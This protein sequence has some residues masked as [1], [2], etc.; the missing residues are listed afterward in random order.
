M[1]CSISWQHQAVGDVWNHSYSRL[2]DDIKIDN[3]SKTSLSFLAAVNLSRH[4]DTIDFPQFTIWNY[5]QTLSDILVD[6]YDT[7]LRWING[8]NDGKKCL[9][10]ANVV[11]S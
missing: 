1:P 6:P 3:S 11:P 2:N 10:R 7:Q 9:E 8:D 5:T 4:G